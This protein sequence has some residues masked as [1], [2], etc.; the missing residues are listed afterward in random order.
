MLLLLACWILS[1]IRPWSVG[2]CRHQRCPAATSQLPVIIPASW[3]CHSFSWRCHSSSWRCHS[4]SWRSYSFSW[5]FHSSFWR[6]NSSATS[7]K[8]KL[9]SLVISSGNCDKPPSKR[10]KVEDDKDSWIALVRNA[11]S[12]LE[13]W[14]L[15]AWIWML[16]DIFVWDHGA[17]WFWLRFLGHNLWL[18][19]LVRIGNGWI[20]ID[21][22][23]E[24]RYIFFLWKILNFLLCRNPSTFQTI[25]I[26][27]N[28]LPG[29]LENTGCFGIFFIPFEPF[30]I[31]LLGP[32]WA[33]SL[34][35][36]KVNCAKNNLNKMLKYCK[37]SVTTF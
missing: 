27:R 8:R 23:S 36:V 5:R 6:C 34:V 9:Q 22:L 14:R 25:S 19:K 30:N 1:K 17:A 26:F 18:T 31:C 7:L 4:F 32:L 21:G 11:D 37:F 13:L 28:G 2:R 24:V 12:L 20:S 10:G 16:V 3:R 33:T 35:K 15:L 29:S